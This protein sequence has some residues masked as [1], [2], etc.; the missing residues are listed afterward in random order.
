MTDSDQPQPT[1]R[2]LLREYKRLYR[3]GYSRLKKPLGQHL[4]ANQEMLRKIASLCR[5]TPLTTVIE[6]GAG[7]GNLTLEL[8]AREPK[9]YIGI[10]LDER[11]TELHHKFFDGYDNVTFIYSDVLELDLKE[12]TES[13]HGE[14]VIVGNIPYQITSPLIMKILTRDARWSRIVFTIQK[15]VAE[16]LAA[17]PGTRTISA[18]TIKIALFARVRLGFHIGANNFIP[19][20]RVDSAVVVFEP[21]SAPLLPPEER[22]DFFRLVEAAYAHRRKT[23]LNSLTISPKIRCGKADIRRYLEKANIDPSCRAESLSLDDFLVLHAAMRE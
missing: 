8:L 21:R 20:P 2:A 11:F 9:R 7:V 3:K 13:T 17:S 15:E 4:L 12:F 5:I 1:T 6:V 10:E 18:F 22:A 16:R 23:L 14:V 19:P